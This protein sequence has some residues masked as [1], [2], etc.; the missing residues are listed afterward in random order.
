MS[1]GGHFKATHVRWMERRN[2]KIESDNYLDQWRDEQCGS[3]R[4]WLPLTGAFGDD[5]GGCSNLKSDVDGL[6]RFEHDGCEYY[7]GEGRWIVQRSDAS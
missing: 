7:E 4:F 1:D 3:C 5:Y 2:R 6:I